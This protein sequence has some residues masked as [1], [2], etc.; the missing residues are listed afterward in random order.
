[1]AARAQVM[2][3]QPEQDIEADCFAGTRHPRETFEF[4]GHNGTEKHLLEL[5][6]LGRLP[7]AYLICGLPGI[8][9]ATLAWRLARF[10]L[11][12]P[13]SAT[14]ALASARNLSV[15]TANPIAKQI[16]GLAHPDLVLLRRNWNSKDQKLYNEIRIDDIRSAMN[17][18]QQSS[19]YGGF[20]ICIIDSTDDLN[21]EG[22]NALLKLIEEPPR[23]SIFLLV[24]NKVSHVLPTIRSRCRH[25]SLRPLRAADISRIILTLGSPWSAVCDQEREYVSSS[26]H[27]SIH[28]A[29][30][31]LR[32]GGPSIANEFE[33]ILANFPVIDWH[34]VH[35][36][37]ERITR[38]DVE[39]FDTLHGAVLDWLDRRIWQDSEAGQG[40]CIEKIVQY[41]VTWDAA[42]AKL[43]RTT[44]FNLQRKSIILALF[45]ELV[46]VALR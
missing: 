35:L 15:S 7:H 23:R 25:L 14:L 30:R 19:A 20:K 43:R 34:K 1:M 21:M 36:L 46:A 11:A 38:D 3:P 12:N 10:I 39:V 37:A 4:F 29:L 18:F 9:K 5:Y 22:M 8:G 33:I 41:S 44:A 13:D 26:A 45:S 6:R 16:V 24:A 32:D 40:A 42:K 2:P 31:L 17:V 28:D 27:G